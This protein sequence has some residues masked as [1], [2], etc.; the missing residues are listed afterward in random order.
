MKHDP[1]HTDTAIADRM[2]AMLLLDRLRD[3]QVPPRVPQPDTDTAAEAETRNHTA[4]PSESL[5][6]SPEHGRAPDTPPA[7][8]LVRFE[9]AMARAGDRFDRL[10]D[11][12]TPPAR[13]GVPSG[14]GGPHRHLW[15][16]V[17]P[18]TIAGMAVILVCFGGVGTW[19][20]LAPLAGAAIATGVVSPDSSRKTIQ[21]LEGGIIR[22]ILVHDG[23]RVE[24][25]QILYKLEVTQAQSTYA[26][27]REQWLRLLATKARLEAHAVDA[28]RMTLSPELTQNEDADLVAFIK[29]QVGLFELRRRGLDER[30]DILRQQLRQLDEQAKGKRLE[31]DGLREQ[32]ALLEEELKDKQ[33]LVSQKLARKPEYLAVQRTIADVRSRI[34]SNISQV[35]ALEERAGEIKLQINNTRTQFRNDNAD[36][37]TKANNDIAQVVE[38]MVAS[39][40]ILKRTAIVAPAAGTILNQRYKTVGGVIRPGEPVVDLVPSADQLIMDAKLP[41]TDIDV[42]K[43]GLPALVHVVPYLTRDTPMLEGIVTHVSADSNADQQTGQRFYEIKVKVERA[44]LDKLAHPVELSPGMPVEVFVVTRNR[45]AL[46]YFVEPITR[47]FRHA[48]RED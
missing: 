22:E 3:A 34:G 23:D 21:H 1:M 25:G 15:E 12:L 44:T 6:A 29:N 9:Q 7:P 8:L 10:L 19:A 32:L 42:V 43:P 2:R 40:D 46:A 24:A 37:L 36:Q 16:L 27:R 31:N 33:I 45:S 17:R 28:E 35:A 48:F 39:Q 30:E 5:S 14:P 26:A 20:A 18:A 4:P 41:A 13:Q 38:A 47:S 11:R